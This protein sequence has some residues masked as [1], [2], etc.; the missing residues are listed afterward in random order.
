MRQKAPSEPEILKLGRKRADRLTPDERKI[1]EGYWEDRLK[2]MGESE[3]RARAQVH[4]PQ[5]DLGDWANDDTEEIRLSGD[6]IREVI[7]EALDE[8]GVLTPEEKQVLEAGLLA[9]SRIKEDIQAVFQAEIARKPHGKPRRVF[10][11]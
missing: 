10:T 7:S 9:I 5:T 3:D 1:L 8:T 2:K 4:T 6:G 11:S